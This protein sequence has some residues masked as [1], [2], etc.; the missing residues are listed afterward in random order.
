VTCPNKDGGIYLSDKSGNFDKLC[1]YLTTGI[2]ISN[3]FFLRNFQTGN[4]L[5]YLNNLITKKENYLELKDPHDVQVIDNLIY[6]V[7]T[8]T[9][10]IKVLDFNLNI[11]KT[12]IFPGEND[13]MHINCINKI[14][15]N[16]YFSCFG[17]FEKQK[18]YNNFKNEAKG[19]VANLNNKQKI[20]T[21]LHQPH[22]IIQDSKKIYILNSAT[23]EVKIFNEHFK[24]VK[25]IKLKGYL[26]G[27][28]VTDKI[29]YIGSSASRNTND[30]INNNFAEIFA[31]DKK[32]YRTIAVAKVPSNEI[33]DIKA[34]H[35]SN[36]L[37]FI[38]KS[39]QYYNYLLNQK[40][41]K[42]LTK[43]EN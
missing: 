26:R 17:D 42:N 34:I 33:Y 36:T 21:N 27:I 2:V 28:E 29:I 5:L 4:Q 13:S 24:N 39:T 19:Y 1:N 43:K 10:S 30:T 11:L 37:N 20:I 41:I 22:S 14:N 31:L 9:N 7:E 15:S 32:N 12:F 18:E 35:Y 3:K 23:S 8:F 16:I 38:Q 40:K 25:N 6:L